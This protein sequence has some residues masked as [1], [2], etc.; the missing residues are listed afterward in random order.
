MGVDVL[1]SP[2]GNES[3]VWERKL[4]NELLRAQ[5]EGKQVAG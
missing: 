3:W 2:G 1:E 5:F 4:G